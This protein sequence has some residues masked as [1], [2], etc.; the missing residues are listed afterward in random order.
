MPTRRRGSPGARPRSAPGS[1]A[2]AAVPAPR[3]LSAHDLTRRLA[4]LGVPA[5]A[6]VAL[7]VSG[8]ADSLALAWLAA[9]AGL[10]AVALHVDHRLRPDAADEAAR[11][12][13]WLDAMGLS[14]QL[15]VRQG[16]RPVA[17]LQARA[18][19]DRYRLLEDW[20][21]AHGVATLVLAHHQG[22]Q[23]E[24]LLL[25]LA[26]GSGVDG[27]AAMAPTAPAV[28]PPHD[29]R[30][31]RPLLDVPKVRLQATLVAA[32]QPWIADPSND[33]PRFDRVKARRLLADPPLPGLSTA[34]LAQTAHRLRRAS[35][36][37]EAATDALL[38][39]AACVAMLPGG[40]AGL[41]TLDR[42]RW[43]TAPEDIRLRAL[44]RLLGFAGGAAYRPREDKLLRLAAALAE[45][46][47]RGAT[48][49][50]CT[51][52]PDR[53]G[54]CTIMRESDAVAEP[55]TPTAPGET[56]WDGRFV[57]TLP[58]AV[59]GDLCLRALG[60]PAFERWAS[61]Q[62]P[63]LT[64]ETERLAATVAPGLPA[65]WSAG[66]PWA[67]PHLDIAPAGVGLRAVRSRP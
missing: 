25:N 1:A 3:P 50:G 63:A 8:G 37:L 59:P 33:D 14:A 10:R 66:A 16:D 13:G 4:A 30:R 35:A 15:L 23:A 5:E 67:V 6:P 64:A 45:P 29:L 47:F 17:N 48:L 39:T 60:R 55:M 62:S 56:V 24:T 58:A 38:D 49:A 12:R 40:P 54:R 65:L 42:A 57:L 19:A 28:T 22:D 18:R 11:V 43:Q 51:L 61:G 31:V 36:A 44:V 20:C 2:E 53:D 41:V 26:R 32:G 27:L 9:R 21:R 52:R 46:G 7:A 34:R